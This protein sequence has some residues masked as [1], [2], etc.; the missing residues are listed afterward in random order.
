VRGGRW[1]L[2]S[3]GMT[4]A[5]VTGL[6]RNPAVSTS[7]QRRRSL[8]RQTTDAEA[9]I[10]RY[11]RDRRFD[12]FKFRR[13]HACG[14]YI[15]DFFCPERRLAIELDGGQ[16]FEPA[17]QQN[18]QRRTAF[19]RARGIWVLRFNNDQVFLE[20]DAVLEAI[21]RALSDPPSP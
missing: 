19:L 15:L 14:P 17:V 5:T 11:L 18:D 3:D 2:P 4:A 9:T 1:Y 12:G 21:A 6:R 20:T 13:Q 7:L 10:W 16:H 8:R